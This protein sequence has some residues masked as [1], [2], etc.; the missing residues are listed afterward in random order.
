MTIRLQHRDRET[1][2]RQDPEVRLSLEKK[3]ARIKETIIAS[4]REVVCH[5]HNSHPNNISFVQ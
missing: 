5:R 3:V 4:L 2:G 1:C